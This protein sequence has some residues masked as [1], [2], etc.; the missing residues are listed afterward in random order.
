M[1][2]MQVCS[3][4]GRSAPLVENHIQQSTNP[5][6]RQQLL[7]IGQCSVCHRFICSLHAE[8]LPLQPTSQ[9]AGFGLVVLGCP[10]DL[11]VPLGPSNEALPSVLELLGESTEAGN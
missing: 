9:A 10:F 11:G 2:Q 6:Q 3:V 5:Q 8:P 7:L 4:C 1:G